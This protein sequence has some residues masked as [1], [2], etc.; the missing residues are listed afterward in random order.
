MPPEVQN[1]INFQ[2][3][4]QPKSIGYWQ[5]LSWIRNLI[6]E[7]ADAM[8]TW[9]NI[10]PNGQILLKQKDCNQFLKQTGYSVSLSME[11]HYLNYNISSLG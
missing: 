3:G 7:S 9:E 11:H 10:S 5:A 6:A 2:K 1:K 4:I 8:S